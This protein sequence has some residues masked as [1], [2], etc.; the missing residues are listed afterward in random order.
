M[1]G[2]YF[3]YFSCFKY[4]KTFTK[5]TIQ[6]TSMGQRRIC[7]YKNRSDFFP[8]KA[9]FFFFLITMGR[10]L[11]IFK[12]MRQGPNTKEVYYDEKYRKETII[13]STISLVLRRFTSFMESMI[14]NTSCTML[15][16]SYNHS[17]H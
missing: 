6:I 10:K 14:N 8:A 17:F 9:H 4:D 3:F 16:V 1:L 7:K 2:L 12:Q 15:K 5:K 11:A 13:Q